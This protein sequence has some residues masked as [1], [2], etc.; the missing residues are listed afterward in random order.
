MEYIFTVAPHE[1]MWLIKLLEDINLLQKLPITMYEDNQSNIK[2]IQSEIYTLK[3]KHIDIKFPF[4]K[5][6]R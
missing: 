6:L 3:T 4:M 2:M 5:H 1:T